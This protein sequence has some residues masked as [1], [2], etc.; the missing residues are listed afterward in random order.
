M[1]VMQKP[2]C[3]AVPTQRVTSKRSPWRGSEGS[4]VHD[5]KQA[6][7][8]T[9]VG[10]H[11]MF[12]AVMP[13]FSYAVLNSPVATIPRT[14]DAALRRSI[15]SFN[16]DVQRIQKLMEKIA[17][18][19][20]I[21][22]RKAWG[23][24]QDSIEEARS[25]AQ[26]SSKMMY[27]VPSDK[28]SQAQAITED[29]LSELGKL[30]LRVNEQD[31]D[32]VSLR[33]VSVLRSVSELKLLQ[34]PGLPYLIPRAYNNQP[35]L[36]GRAA[37]QLVISNGAVESNVEIVL[38]GYSSPL[39]AGAFA[40]NVASHSFDQQKLS[41]DR[42]IV[43]LHSNSQDA[44]NTLPLEILPVGQFEPLYRSELDVQTGE[45]PVLPLSIF[46]SVSLSHAPDADEMS[47]SEEAFIFKFNRDTAG[48]G[49]LAFDEGKFSVIGYVTKGL[50]TIK[51]LQTG[52]IIV[53]ADIVN[54]QEN[55]ILPNDS[56]ST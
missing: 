42:D 33:V 19:L 55:L 32:G 17:F 24:M 40:A 53:R 4:L 51:T 50:E 8:G 25:L 52:N 41:V 47:S 54:G 18:G 49:G 11:W 44:S 35:R 14:A 56:L 12:A 20:R 1:T 37:V 3:L 30:E 34:T 36:I 29:V 7:L 26:D 22:Q 16:A 15:P 10:I 43:V 13:D 9:M 45:V 2:L 48:L 5:L 39:S 23:S 31:S 46:G 28:Q 27:G 21:P 38:D 6:V